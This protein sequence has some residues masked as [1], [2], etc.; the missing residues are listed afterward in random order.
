MKTGSG[1]RSQ[2]ALLKTPRFLPF[3][4]TQFLGAFN[5]NVFKNALIIFITFYVA[6]LTDAEV[7]TLINTAAGLFILPFFLFSALAG[8]IAD[9]VEK[10]LLIRRIKLA[11]IG[12]MVLAGAGFFMGH[13]GFLVLVLFIMGTQSAFFGPVK[14]SIL[15]Q[16]LKESELV[17]GNALVEM[18]TFLA[19][20]IGT[21][22]GGILAGLGDSGR[23]WV[24]AVVLLVAVSG[25][26]SSR[27]IPRAKAPVPELELNLNPI[28]QTVRVLRYTFQNRVVF[29]S[30]LGISWFWFYGALLLAQ[31]PNYTKTVLGGDAQVV[32]LLLATFSIGI[33]LGSLLC[34][35]MSGRKVEIGLVPFGAIGLTIFAF[36]L[37]FASPERPAGAAMG[38]GAFLQQPGSVRILLDLTLM[39]LF[40]G[41]Y[42]VPLYALVQ[43]RT[44]AENRARVIAGNNIWNALFMVVSALFAIGM[45]GAGVTI[46]NLF[47]AVGLLNVAV[48]VYI[49]KLVPEFLMRFIVWMLVRSVYR[50]RVKNMDAIPETGPA[51][52]VCNH[53]SFVDALIIM[54]ACRRPIRFIMHHGIFKLPIM[55]FVFRTAGAIPVASKREDP[56]LREAAFDEVARGLTRGDL[57][58][59]F[60][61]GQITYDGELGE[62]RPGIE[63]IVKRTPVPVVPMALRGLYGSFF[64]RLGGAAMSKPVRL[65]TRFWSEVELIA[66]DPVPADGVRAEDLRNTVLELRGERR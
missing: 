48:S 29:R 41:F 40:G 59:I 3:F 12:I 61:E 39:A 60:P 43:Q 37:A 22:V 50:L 5:D 9:K 62:F 13:P 7:N 64:S 15:P 56:A 66:A 55:S 52:L 57:I 18:G 36:D 28:T 26:I 1:A 65:L 21:I 24:S 23:G 17:G 31:L 42:S 4:I 35:R 30:I 10:S 38:I 54:A 49:F 58:G 19:I 25:W 6:G 2:F 20:L 51:V 34:E 45:L 14:Y 16:H 53:V 8:Q 47:L 44:Q 46:P 11:E 27:K 33:G 32:T 63:R